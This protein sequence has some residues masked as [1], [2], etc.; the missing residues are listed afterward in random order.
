MKNRNTGFKT[1]PIKLLS[2]S[3]KNLPTPPSLSLEIDVVD[4]LMAPIEDS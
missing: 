2:V 4:V 3:K 1:P